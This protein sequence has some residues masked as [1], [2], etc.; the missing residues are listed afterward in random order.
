[1]LAKQSSLLHVFEFW[2]PEFSYWFLKN[3][4]NYSQGI[5]NFVPSK[6]L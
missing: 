3:S 1:M 4:W 6:R 5:I 2:I